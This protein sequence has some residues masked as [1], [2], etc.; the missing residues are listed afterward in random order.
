MSIIWW[1]CMPVR[2][3]A[4]NCAQSMTFTF[5]HTSIPLIYTHTYTYTGSVIHG[6][7]NTVIHSIIDSVL[8][9]FPPCFS[10]I[11][12]KL[13]AIRSVVLYCQYILEQKLKQKLQIVVIVLV[14]AVIVIHIFIY[15]DFF[16]FHFVVIVVVIVLNNNNWFLTFAFLFYS[17]LLIV[18][19]TPFPCIFHFIPFIQSLGIIVLHC[20]CIFI[21]VCIYVCATLTQWQWLWQ[22]KL[23]V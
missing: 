9:A 3:W 15:F 21:G 22:R 20:I 8:C 4:I 6:H 5:K 1:I 17:W 18:P 7:T 14:V 16:Y 19:Q 12:H 2:F 11:I 23:F 10:A 13:L